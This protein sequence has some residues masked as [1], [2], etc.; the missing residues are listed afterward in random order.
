MK[1]DFTAKQNSISS[2]PLWDAA[3]RTQLEQLGVSLGKPSYIKDLW[4]VFVES[5]K[6]DE[7]KWMMAIAG[8][9]WAVLR[10]LAHRLKGSSGRVAAEK[11]YQQFT[12]IQTYIDLLQAQRS[13]TS[14]NHQDF[15]AACSRIPDLISETAGSLD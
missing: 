7:S 11:L 15:F 12:L 2:I 1:L 8:E 6:K 5:W 14:L 9:D 13:R 10:D 3:S 4:G